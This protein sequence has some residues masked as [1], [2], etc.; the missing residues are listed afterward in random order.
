MNEA[1]ENH[2]N[3]ANTILRQL[4]T[5]LDEGNLRP[6]DALFITV[7]A[8]AQSLQGL[9]SLAVCPGVPAENSEDTGGS[10]PT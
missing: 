9:L 5:G 1:A 7:L 6:E 4:K 10:L 3:V 8:A 2:Y